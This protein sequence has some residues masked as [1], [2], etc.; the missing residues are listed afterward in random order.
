M[1][2]EPMSDRE[3]RELLGRTNVA[4]LACTFNNQPYVVPIHFDYYDGF[5][6]GCSMPGQKIDWMRA[7]PLVC[8]EIDDVTSREDWETAVVF[9]QY[10]E[11]TDIAEYVHARKDAEILFQRR[12]MWW[13]P[14]TV[15]LAGHQAQTAI[16]FRILIDRMSG[17]RARGERDGI[18]AAEL[19]REHSKRNWLR[20]IARRIP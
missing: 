12:P 8:V 13:E 6:Y 3:C 14:S 11:L 5:L 16:L 7:N 18:P 19:T 17:R 4:R 20:A 15:P 10:E 2:I 9:G 1:M